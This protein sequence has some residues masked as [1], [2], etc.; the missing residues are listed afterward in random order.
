MT[1]F[2]NLVKKKKPF[3]L[4]HCI[5]ISNI[6]QVKVSHDDISHEMGNV[7]KINYSLNM[8][9]LLVLLN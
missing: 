4:F 6:T 9:K 2:L 1:R 5:I 8:F 7:I 3:L